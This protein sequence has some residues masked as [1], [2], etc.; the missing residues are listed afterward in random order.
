MNEAGEPVKPARI[1]LGKR[2]CRSTASSDDVLP[3]PVS[4]ISHVPRSSPSAARLTVS[5]LTGEAFTLK[6]FPEDTARPASVSPA[7]TKSA[8][9]SRMVRLSSLRP[10]ARPASSSSTMATAASRSPRRRRFF[11]RMGSEQRGRR[12]VV[13]EARATLACT[14]GGFG[15]TD[16]ACPWGD[17]RACPGGGRPLAFILYAKIHPDMNA[18][19]AAICDAVHWSLGRTERVVRMRG[20]GRRLR[21]STALRAVGLVALAAWGRL[22]QRSAQ[23][24][25]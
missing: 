1:E 18:P 16:S 15:F 24:K 4:F 3:A 9:S 11:E 23:T 20:D 19:A 5:V 25:S 21:H 14:V 2:G 8:S 12:P 17:V 22:F 6:L 7:T 13:I 10:A